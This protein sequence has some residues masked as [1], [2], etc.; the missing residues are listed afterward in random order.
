MEL[1]A[2]V[3]LAGGAAR[4]MGGGDKGLLQIGGRPILTYVIAR[5]RPQTSVVALSANGDPARLA[6]FDLPILSDGAFVGAGPLAGILAGMR[7]ARGLAPRIEVLLSVPTDTPFLPLDLLSKLT[8]AGHKTGA[9]VA[10]AASGGRTHFTAAL[11]SLALADDLERA[12]EEGLRRVEQFAESHRPTIVDFPADP[13][14]PFF[15][16]NRPEDLIRAEDM[17]AR[18]ALAP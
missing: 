2:A 5:L 13:I 9:P 15:N 1:T 12:L 7:W 6:A 16:I 18:Q 3:I 17:A 8:I 11:W 10:L 14:D 4:R